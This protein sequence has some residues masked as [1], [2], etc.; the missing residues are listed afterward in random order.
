MASLIR[1]THVTRG[2]SERV[3]VFVEESPY[4][5]RG[6][7]EFLR[8]A[9]EQ[10]PSGARVADIGM[11]ERPYGELFGHAQYCVIDWDESA[12]EVA[13]LLD[14]T[15]SNGSS[16]AA[17]ELFD[18]LLLV[19]VLGRVP[20]PAATLR[21]AHG[22]LRPGGAVYL[23]AP[24][25]AESSR[26]ERDCFRFTP[27]TIEHLLET[28]GFEDVGVSPTNDCFSTIAQLLRDARGAMGRSDDGLDERRAAAAAVLDE[29]AGLI[30]DLAPL[31]V[32]RV[33]PLGYNVEARRSADRAVPGR[34]SERP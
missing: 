19:D 6:L 25:M 32:R 30:A 18:V 2:V 14:M 28:S 1:A 15:A 4:Q 10:T 22:L 7:L 33:L 8:H 11:V 3:R 9:A 31:D 34:V 23:T 5:R 13:S 16:A 26:S 21:Q 29:L 20:D 12:Q 24:L 17:A 27:A